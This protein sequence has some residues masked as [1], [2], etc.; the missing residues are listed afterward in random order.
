MLLAVTSRWRYE[1]TK[2]LLSFVYLVSLWTLF[3]S[4]AA[5]KMASETVTDMKGNVVKM[6]ADYSQ[7]V[8]KTLPECEAHVKVA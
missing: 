2:Q 5:S 3:I 1:H 6:E 4:S 7:T 8:D